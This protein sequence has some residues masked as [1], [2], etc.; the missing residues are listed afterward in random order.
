MRINYKMLPCASSKDL[1]STFR[2]TPLTLRA[3]NECAYH[4][5]MLF[6]LSKPNVL[7]Y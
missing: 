1:E 7:A 2:L 3:R 4:L 6:Y 5:F